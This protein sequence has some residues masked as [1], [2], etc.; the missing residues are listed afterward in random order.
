MFC[1]TETFSKANMWLMRVTESRVR[2]I[3]CEGVPFGHQNEFNFKE[4]HIL[5]RMELVNFDFNK[6]NTLK[7][8][9]D[10]TTFR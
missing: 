10:D 3:R 4:V 6:G 2:P 8:H 1:G 5:G 7:L 9:H